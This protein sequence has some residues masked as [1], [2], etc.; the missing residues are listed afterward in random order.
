[1]P[2]AICEP[3]S[4]RAAGAA[5]A[6]GFGGALGILTCDI[7]TCDI[8]T[9]DIAAWVMTAWGFTSAGAVT[10]DK[11]RGGGASATFWRATG[12]GGRR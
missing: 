2:G 8:L 7:L 5:D 10:K 12:R 6:A 9:W 11:A 1:M 4:G 3:G